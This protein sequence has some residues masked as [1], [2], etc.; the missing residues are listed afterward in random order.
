M[1]DFFI[2]TPL[3]VSRYAC[4]ENSHLQNYASLELEHSEPDTDCI[5]KHYLIGMTNKCLQKIMPSYDDLLK[6]MISFT[7]Y[8]HKKT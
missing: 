3:N 4:F 8:F 7:K 1:S 5:D 6:K 2:S